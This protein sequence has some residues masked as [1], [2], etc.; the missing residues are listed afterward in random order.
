LL[1]SSC[2]PRRARLNV[3]RGPPAS[4]RVSSP[5]QKAGAAGACSRHCLYGARAQPSNT[6][7][8]GDEKRASR[9]RVD[10][11]PLGTRN[12][13]RADARSSGL[14][15]EASAAAQRDPC[16]RRPPTS[17]QAANPRSSSDPDAAHTARVPNLGLRRRPFPQ[18]TKNIRKLRT[19]CDRR[20]Q[21]EPR[22]YQ[23]LGPQAA[24]NRTTENRGV[25][26]SSPGLAIGNGPANQGLFRG[27]GAAVLKGRRRCFAA[28]PRS[29]PDP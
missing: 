5:P 1:A 19:S 13:R 20:T 29:G 22:N 15:G 25:P 27:R 7:S 12:G 28:R 24:P 18:T 9:S 6:R 10:P 26:S 14:H 17:P 11:H 21:G 23:D 16:P 4:T 3:Q 2:T 8:L